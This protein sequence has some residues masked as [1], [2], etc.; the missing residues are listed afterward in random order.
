MDKILKKK[1][2]LYVIL[3]LMKIKGIETQGQI[4]LFGVMS[5]ETHDTVQTNRASKSPVVGGS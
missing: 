1:N 3:S 5:G 2:K 4:Q